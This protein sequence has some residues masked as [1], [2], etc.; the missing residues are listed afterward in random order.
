MSVIKLFVQQQCAKCP[1]AKELG[2][3]L[4]QEGCTVLEYD[5]GT[6][7]GLA[8]ATFYGVQATPTFI[9]EDDQE[10]MIADFRG[11]LPVKDELRQIAT[12]R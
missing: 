9:V 11:T 12:A 6:T 8:E 5:V 10:N 7:E 3:A 2:Q 1:Q 4:R